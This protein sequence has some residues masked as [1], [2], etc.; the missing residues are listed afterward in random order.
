MTA[1]DVRPFTA[2]VHERPELH[3]RW[4]D[5]AEC[6]VEPEFGQGMT[7]YLHTR[8]LLH[9]PPL[10][11]GPG[12]ND[13]RV[14][15]SRSD[16]RRS[17]DDVLVDVQDSAVELDPAKVHVTGLFADDLDAEQARRLSVALGAAAAIVEAAR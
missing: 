11:P 9:E 4:C 6:S 14:E 3:P 8:V 10:E 1:V 15:V 5:P 17:R 13:L 16:L 7:H 2:P 12:V